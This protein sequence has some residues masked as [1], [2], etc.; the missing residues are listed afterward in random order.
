VEDDLLCPL[1]LGWLCARR[2]EQQANDQQSC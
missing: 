2:N 1:P